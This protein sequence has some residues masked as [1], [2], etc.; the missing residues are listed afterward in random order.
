MAFKKG[1]KRYGKGSSSLNKLKGQ[2][3][4][5]KRGT[6][7][8][9]SQIPHIMMDALAG[10]GKTFTEIIGVAYI[11]RDSVV[12]GTSMTVWD[13]VEEELGFQVVPSDEQLA[14][15]EALC[16]G[17][18]PETILYCA[19]NKSI[20]TDF[21]EKYRWLVNVLQKI[22]V[23]LIF[24]TM[25]SQ[26]N[27]ACRKHF[28]L[29]GWN[30]VDRFR[31]SKMFE[32]MVGVDPR[33]Y[34]RENPGVAKA[35]EDLVGLAK[36]NMLGYIEGSAS[37][38]KPEFAEWEH[39]II[40]YG[41]EMPS[42]QSYETTVRMA[43]VLWEK[44]LRVEGVIDFNDQVWLPAI[45]DL[46]MP[47]FKLAIGDE[48]QDW[49]PAQRAL[50][51]K[52]GYRFLV[53]GDVNQAI[54]GF[55]GADV[56]SMDKLA[57]E[58]EKMGGVRRFPLNTTRRC[59]KAVVREAQQIVPS[60]QAHPDNEEGMVD[61]RSASEAISEY[62]EEDMVVCRVN[63]PLVSQ[64]FRLI[65][66]GK[67]A[68]IQGRDIGTGL[69][70]LIRRLG[71]KYWKTMDVSELMDKVDNWYEKEASFINKRKRP[72]NDALIAL[73][74]KKECIEAVASGALSV[75]EIM[76][77]IDKIFQG[78]VCPQCKE[79]FNE[80]A[81]MCYKCKVMLVTPEGVLF[82]SIHRC[83]GL[84]ANHVWFLKPELCPHPMA[85]QD[86]ARKQEMN[87]KYVAITRAISHLT[88]VRGD[89]EL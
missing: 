46:P 82:T 50:A 41:I 13:T 39:L 61:Y 86:W 53:C 47:R 9:F 44:S 2:L 20:V 76:S 38:Q 36:L 80:T 52:L 85:K 10:T 57:A 35:V 8:A 84:E 74:D 88:Y 30:S 42:C 64:A 5:V 51:M 24:S 23:T 43:E 31:T 11:Y 34:D 17:A 79:S 60:F 32:E 77:N 67:R 19:F 25:H 37:P 40:H 56:D 66:A 70:N 89:E 28:D 75:D 12:P 21:G 59:C 71:G 1:V 62:N 63:A 69:K 55:A 65:K 33:Q 73:R 14:V 87:L 81:E 83:K 54:Y 26:G 45:S 58:L 7:R 78:K 22:G 3:D 6:G 18:K 27:S 48:V 15:W 68:N 49:N 29:K 4:S 72:N 16:E